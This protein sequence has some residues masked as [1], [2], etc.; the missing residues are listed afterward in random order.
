MEHD[1][2]GSAVSRKEKYY[3]KYAVVTVLAM[4]WVVR[5]IAWRISQGLWV[6]EDV[7]EETVKDLVLCTCSFQNNFFL[8]C[9]KSRSL[10]AYWI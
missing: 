5:R 8:N 1:F 7:T 3:A 4:S 9:G 6:L 2:R 10:V